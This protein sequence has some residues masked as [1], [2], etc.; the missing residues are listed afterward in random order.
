MFSEVNSFDTL[1][2]HDLIV[3]G[4]KGRK[5]LATSHGCGAFLYPYFLLRQCCEGSVVGTM[6]TAQQ[7]YQWDSQIFRLEFILAIQGKKRRR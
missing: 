2:T 4:E 5:S 1:Y 6:N 7:K 3:Q